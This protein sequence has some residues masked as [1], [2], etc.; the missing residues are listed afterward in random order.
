MKQFKLTIKRLDN[1]EEFLELSNKIMK[2]LY[3]DFDLRDEPEFCN[4]TLSDLLGVDLMDLDVMVSGNDWPS[5]VK[6][7][8][9]LKLVGDQYGISDY[10]CPNCGSPDWY[11][12][13]YRMLCNQC[14]YSEVAEEPFYDGDIAD[15]SGFV[16]FNKNQIR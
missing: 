9:E 3:K 14:E 10:V 7:L 12:T 15:Y 11:Y 6:R 5:S 16:S 2:H 4:M 1:S 8:G 13:G